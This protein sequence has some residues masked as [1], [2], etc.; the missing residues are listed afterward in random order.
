MSTALSNCTNFVVGE[1]ITSLYQ[2]PKKN[3]LMCFGNTINSCIFRFTEQ[4]ILKL[5]YVIFS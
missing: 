1:L 2:L 3:R 4:N 5:K